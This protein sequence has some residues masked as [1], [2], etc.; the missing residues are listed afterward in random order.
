ME[1]V[2]ITG[3]TR[4]AKLQS[5]CH[6]QQTNAQRFIGRVPFLLPTKSV[7]A[8][9]GKTATAS[10]EMYMLDEHQPKH[11]TLGTFPT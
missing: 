11:H 2:L 1:V 7:R 10:C 4:C 8:T 3:A 9:E 6:Q 5:N